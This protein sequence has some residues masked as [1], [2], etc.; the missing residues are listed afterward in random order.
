MNLVPRVETA[1]IPDTDLDQLSGGNAGAAASVI[2]TGGTAAAG[3][4]AE[5]GPLGFSAGLDA[6]LAF[7]G[8]AANGNARTTSV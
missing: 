3:L 2:A 4:Y 8:V 1:E 5:A 6:S 7:D